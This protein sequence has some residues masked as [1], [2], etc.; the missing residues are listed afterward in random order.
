[1]AVELYDGWYVEL[2]TYFR[3]TDV[4]IYNPGEYQRYNMQK[5]NAYFSALGWT[6]N[7][8]AGMLGNMMVESTVNPWLFEHHSRNWDDV[9][10]ILADTGGMGLTQWTPC[11]KYYTWAVES[12]LDPKSGDSQCA[13]I[14]WERENKKQWS[15][16]NLG[17]HTWEQFVTSTESP[18]TLARVF[19]WA[20]ERPGNP[21]MEQRQTNAQWCYDFLRGNPDPDPD[22]TPPVPPDP[23]PPY[24]LPPYLFFQFIKRKRRINRNV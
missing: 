20:Y 9:P 16:N 3:T 6:L 4:R 14:E 24:G 10:G 13:R 19:C 1:M 8:I 7:A 12:G 11:R 18:K 15:L 22:P 23:D 21:D 5:V 2:N 17:H